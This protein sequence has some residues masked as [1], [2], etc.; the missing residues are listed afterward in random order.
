MGRII[1]LVAMTNPSS[2]SLKIRSQTA[3]VSSK[4]NTQKLQLLQ[5]K[6]LRSGSLFLNEKYVPA[7]YKNPDPELSKKLKS[8]LLKPPLNSSEDKHLKL[9]IPP[10]SRSATPD[11]SQSFYRKASHFI[12][13]CDRFKHLLP[14]KRTIHEHILPPIYA[15]C[16]D[17]FNH[18]KT[19]QNKDR[20]LVTADL[21]EQMEPL[22]HCRYL[23]VRSAF[24][25]T[26][27][28]K[29]G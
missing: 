16:T 11:K 17:N 5:L 20:E 14:E 2:S 3:P 7:F 12:T 10:R 18:K 26:K 6:R 28:T 4:S 25:V 9:T 19:H 21:S 8:F 1:L 24:D 27:R 23:R 22:K 29:E 15:G 13:P